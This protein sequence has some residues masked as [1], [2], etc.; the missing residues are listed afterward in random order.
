MFSSLRPIFALLCGTAFLLAASGL[1]GLLLPLRGQAEE[2]STTSLGL[3]GTAWAFGF[4]VGCFF[5]P[6][7]VRRAGHIRSFAAL[8]ATAA[9]VA[10]ASGLWIG[11]VGW[12]IL[13]AFTGFAMA[14]AFMIIESWLN[15]R[16]TNEN[17]GTVFGLYM[18]VTYA[19]IMAGQMSVAFADVTTGTLFLLA[20]ILFCA[21]LIPTAV[22]SA[23]SP[24]PLADVSLDLK[25]LF[26]NSP[27]AFLGC[28]LVGAANGAWGTLGPVYGSRI[29]ISNFEIALMMSVVVLAGAAAQLPV[30]RVSDRMDRRIVLAAAALGSALFALIIFATAPR[31]GT[32]IIVLTALYGTLAYTLYSITVAHA[33]DH[34]DP[35][36]FVQVSGGLL[37]LYGFG[38]MFGPVIG[39]FLMDR[40]RPE[41]IFLATALP[42]VALCIYAVW[43]MQRRA[44]VPIDEREDFKTIPAERALTPQGSLLDP[45]AD[46]DQ[47]S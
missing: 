27:V 13:R 47:E 43:R 15:E 8:A 46:A 20:G 42:H 38:T 29:G 24:Q 18:M 39:A 35:T 23:I 37:L 40:M 17:R 44:P 21:S 32:T 14:G 10:L 30:G 3:L 16:A 45:R 1:H 9:I 22:S 33:N 26:A 34:A 11:E 2:F 31:G 7:L 6:R 4:V 19:A 5:C 41:S 12:I 28:F 36:E 25:K